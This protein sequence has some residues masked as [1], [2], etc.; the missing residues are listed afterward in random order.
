MI[1]A[2]ALHYQALGA[3]GI[4]RGLIGG[5]AGALLGPEGALTGGLE[6][7]AAGFIDKYNQ[8]HP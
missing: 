5:I 1:L 8:C 4:V 7:A 6:G 2:Q 3:G